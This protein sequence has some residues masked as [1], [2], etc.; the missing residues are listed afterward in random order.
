MQLEQ[1]VAEAAAKYTN[2]HPVM[3]Q[4]N[5]QLGAINKRI[6]EL[7]GT[8]KRLPELQRQ[9][10]QLFREV[11][12]KQQLYTGLLN[13]YQQLRIAK[14]GEIGN[15][16]IVDTAVEPIEPIKP[17]KLQILILSVFLGWLSGYIVGLT[18]KTSR[19]GNQVLEIKL[20][21]NWIYLF[22]PLYHIHLCKKAVLKL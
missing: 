21:M 20:K 8:L 15:V 2:E 11:E 22:M 18:A 19:G 12:V 4:M 17:K 16:R 5:A 10:L 1:Q 9:Y 13:S 3:Q 7:D 14:A 6:A